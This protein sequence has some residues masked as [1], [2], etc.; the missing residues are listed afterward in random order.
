MLF[1]LS[2]ICVLCPSIS[3]EKFTCLPVYEYLSY[4]LFVAIV[5]NIVPQLLPVSS[6]RYFYKENNKWML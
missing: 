3:Y 2:I 1:C 4:F 6:S 5:S